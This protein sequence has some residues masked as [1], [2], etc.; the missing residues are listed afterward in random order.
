MTTLKAAALF[1]DGQTRLPRFCE[2]AD[3]T[4][5]L[6]HNDGRI[7]DQWLGLEPEEFELLWRLATHPGKRVWEVSASSPERGLA[8]RPDGSMELQIRRLRKKLQPFGL[9]DLIVRHELGGVL[10]KAP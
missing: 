8:A 7:A 4:L 2:I 1:S 10:L 3:L 9:E 6:F 5:D